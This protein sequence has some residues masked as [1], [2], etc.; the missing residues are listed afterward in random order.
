MGGTPGSAHR[1]C[2]YCTVWPWQA[3]ELSNSHQTCTSVCVGRVCCLLLYIFC[4]LSLH[5]IAVNPSQKLDWFQDHMPEK[6]GN[7]KAI[8]VQAVCS[9][10]WPNSVLCNLLILMTALSPLERT[11][12]SQPIATAPSNSPMAA[13]ILG[14]GRSQQ[15]GVNLSLEREVEAHLDDMEEGSSA[16]V[17]WQVSVLNTK[18]Y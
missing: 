2:A 17:Y 8:F 4:G 13:A 11:Q 7:A 6:Y 5:F 10:S 3:D 12:F 9:I 14:L 1:N 15:R 16:L 18:C